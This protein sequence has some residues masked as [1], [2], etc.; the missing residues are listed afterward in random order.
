MNAG[1]ILCLALVSQTPTLANASDGWQPGE[2]HVVP[3]QFTTGGAA[4]QQFQTNQFQRQ[5][6]QPQHGA[7]VDRYG[8]TMAPSD[9]NARQQAPAQTQTTQQQ[10]G[11]QHGSPPWSHGGSPAANQQPPGNAQFQNNGQQ[12]PASRFGTPNQQQ[13]DPRFAGNPQNS[14]GNPQGSAATHYGQGHSIRGQAQFGQQPGNSSWPSHAG[15]QNGG[16]SPRGQQTA[17]QPRGAWDGGWDGTQQGEQGRASSSP[18]N[19]NQQNPDRRFQTQQ[20]TTPQQPPHDNGSPRNR[21]AD[22]SQSHVAGGQS[23]SR[24]GAPVNTGGNQLRVAENTD[25]QQNPNRQQQPQQQNGPALQPPANQLLSGQ[26]F[27][28]SGQDGGRFSL[29]DSRNDDGRFQQNERF[30]MGGQ[31]SQTSPTAAPPNEPTDPNIGNGNG[32]N[33]AALQPPLQSTLP[34]GSDGHSDNRRARVTPF[35]RVQPP[36]ADAPAG[37]DRVTVS[38]SRWNQW[39]DSQPSADDSVQPATAERQTSGDRKTQQAGSLPS[40]VGGA[41]QSNRT[42][43]AENSPH[44][45]AARSSQGSGLFASAGMNKSGDSAQ[46]DAASDERGEESHTEAHSPTTTV[47]VSLIALFFSLGGNLYLGWIAFESHFRYRRLLVEGDDYDDPPRRA[48]D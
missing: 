6:F 26:R 47:V 45:G 7:G 39:Q 23:G 28:P 5:A 37:Q 14:S 10:T 43:A 2:T 22:L 8:R 29:G 11:Q 42:S 34:S 13:A 9:Q 20:Q 3:S 48:R 40:F 18:W 21:Q 31:P 32:Q 4:S 36:R 30:Q 1:W 38:D 16:P 44:E 46:E 17:P 12:N 27:A 25:G 41:T 33:N 15:T 35:A 24:F 19:R